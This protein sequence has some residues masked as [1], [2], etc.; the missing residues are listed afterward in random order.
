MMKTRKELKDEYK[1]KKSVMGI[2]QIK[3]RINN[4]IF[5]GSSADLKAIWNRY[6]M[7]LKFGNHPNEALQKDWNEYGEENFAYEIITELKQEE[8]KEIDYLKEL[9][10]LEKLFLNELKP[11]GE[12]GYNKKKNKKS[13]N[14]NNS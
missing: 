7:M 1:Q 14:P 9:Q 11:F 6:K 12:R 3:N 5:I 4:K 13:L 2:F 8:D 10:E